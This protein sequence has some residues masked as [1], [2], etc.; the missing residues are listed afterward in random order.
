[1]SRRPQPEHADEATRLADA[2]RRRDKR[3]EALLTLKALGAL[4]LVAVA[5]V[6]REIYF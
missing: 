3:R 4:A 5:V 6:L 2:E 1:M